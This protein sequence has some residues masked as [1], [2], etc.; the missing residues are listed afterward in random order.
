M[1]DSSNQAQIRVVAGIINRFTETLELARYS[2]ALDPPRLDQGIDISDG[3]GKVLG[4]LLWQ[5]V[6][7]TASNS[8]M[9][10][11][12]DEFLGVGARIRVRRTVRITFHRDRRHTDIR[13]RS[14]LA[15]H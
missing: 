15:L 10:V 8:P 6:S 12:A 11:L 4:R 3:L 5:V 9:L 7:D 1:N 2:R 13:E 14:E